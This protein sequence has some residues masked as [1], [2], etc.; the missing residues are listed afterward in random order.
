MR[1]AILPLVIHRESQFVSA[2]N[3]VLI[4]GDTVGSPHCSI[5]RTRKLTLKI[6]FNIF[7]TQRVSCFCQYHR[8]DDLIT[9]NLRGNKWPSCGSSW[10]KNFT[11]LPPQVCCSTLHL[12]SLCLFGPDQY[13]LAVVFRVF[14]KRSLK[15][16]SSQG[17]CERLCMAPPYL[18]SR[19]REWFRRLFSWFFPIEHPWRFPEHVNIV[20]FRRAATIRGRHRQVCVGRLVRSTRPK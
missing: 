15:A 17:Q 18:S 14:R 6:T 4:V 10:W 13:F 8:I 12:A 9:C 2:G 16:A 7:T 11:F 5:L 20:Q 1:F 3:D 19:C